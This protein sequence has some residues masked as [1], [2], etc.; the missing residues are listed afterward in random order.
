MSQHD[1][2][3]ALQQPNNT[4][5]LI[6]NPYP[7]GGTIVAPMKRHLKPY[8]LVTEPDEVF[9]PADG[10][11]VLVPIP[12]DQAGP[13][14]ILGAMFEDNGAVTGQWSVMLYDANHSALLQNRPVMVNTIASDRRGLP[15]RWPETYLIH[16]ED[17]GKF[18]LASFQNYSN[19]GLNVRFTL[20]GRRMYWQESKKKLYEEWMWYTNKRRWTSPW[21]YTTESN[22]VLPSGASTHTGFIRVADDADFVCHRILRNSRDLDAPFAP[23]EFTTRWRIK[24]NR[25]DQMPSEMNSEVVAGSG[26][27]PFQTFENTL[28][29]RNSQI[30]IDFTSDGGNVDTNIDLVMAGRKIHY[31]QHDA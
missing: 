25:Q 30:E 6:K 2:L 20:I 16:P 5:T 29:A 3:F 24:G 15:N 14:E 18:I 26:D 12:V 9:L 10:E 7:P 28:Y 23:R 1:P 27:F 22:V 19:V 11:P 8:T 17:C 21:F 4:T 13:I 31:V